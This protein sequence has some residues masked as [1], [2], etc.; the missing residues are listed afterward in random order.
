M[1]ER[2]PDSIVTRLAYAGQSIPDGSMKRVLRSVYERYNTKKKAE[3]VNKLNIVGS[4][5]KDGLAY[6]ELSDG[7]VYYGFKSDDEDDSKYK[8]L[9]KDIKNKLAPEAYAVAEEYYFYAVSPPW[10]RQRFSQI[11]EGD[12]IID[13][14]ANKGYYTRKLSS[15]VGPEGKVLA[16]EA[17]P[18]NYEVLERNINKAPLD[19]VTPIHAAASDMLGEIE[20]Y[21]VDTRSGRHHTIDYDDR[22]DIIKTLSVSCKTIDDMAERD[23][24]R[25]PDM[26]S[27]TI[28]GHECQALRGALQMLETGPLVCGPIRPPTEAY[29]LFRDIGYKYRTVDEPKF[30]TPIIYGSP[31][32]FD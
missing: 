25:K 23:T 7:E 20:F 26:I 28:N 1:I 10:D 21:E 15:I 3:C 13:V 18:D 19:N 14:G 27:L 9:E 24:V 2:L 11:E 29:S 17:H 16:I 8:I 32:L 4:G 6:I 31:T 22:D 5:T 30:Q 12:V